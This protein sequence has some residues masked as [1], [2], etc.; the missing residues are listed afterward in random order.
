MNIRELRQQREELNQRM[1]AMNDEVSDREETA[2]ELAN[3]DQAL[4]DRQALDRKIERAEALAVSAPAVSKREIETLV[5]NPPTLEDQI[6]MTSEDRAVVAQANFTN[7]L[8]TGYNLRGMPIFEYSVENVRNFNTQSDIAFQATMRRL[9]DEGHAQAQTYVANEMRDVNVGTPADGGYTVQDEAM[10]PIVIAE[11]NYNGVLN[12]GVNAFS[13][14]TGGPLPVPTVNDTGSAATLVAEAA[15]APDSDFVFGQIVLGDFKYTSGSI[16]LS[17]E[18]LQDSSLMVDSFLSRMIGER[19]G[20]GMGAHFTS[21]TGTN[22]PQGVVT[23]AVAGVSKA[24]NTSAI[25][26]EDLVNLQT[27][28]D[29]AYQ[30]NA[31]W[32]MNQNTLGL[33]RRITGSGNQPIFDPVTAPGIPTTIL[34]RPY[35][36]NDHMEDIGNGNTPLLYGDFSAYYVR[37]ISGITI[38]RQIETYAK[39]DQIGIVAFA[40]ADAR[41]INAGGNPVKSFTVA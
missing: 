15:N 1:I 23:A 16:L 11:K 38:K 12:A 7:W 19:F 39:S 22:Q 28:V 40:R 18:F 2:E 3:W 17:S 41:M 20:R 26:Y 36:I 8:K 25:T 34:D 14:A 6:D 35:V 10:A 13:T 24:T 9:A 5:D 32:M 31:R 37:N 21:G 29:G 27:S 33:L 4:A 30:S